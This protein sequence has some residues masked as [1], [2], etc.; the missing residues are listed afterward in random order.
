MSNSDRTDVR[1]DLD[2]L[3]ECPICTEVFTDPRSL[4]CIHT[5]CLRCIVQWSRNG[6][7]GDLISCPMC[8]KKFSIPL[9]GLECLPK[10]FFMERLKKT[11]ELL[12]SSTSTDRSLCEACATEGADLSGIEMRQRATN[13][14]IDCHQRFCDSCGDLH[15]KINVARMHRTIR[16]D[17]EESVEGDKRSSGA[18]A[19][20]RNQRLPEAMC[21]RHVTES[22]KLFCDNCE[23]AICIMCF[24]ECHQ[25]HKCSDVNQV[26]DVFRRRMTEDADELERGVAK[27]HSW[28][29]ELED[30]KSELAEVTTRIKGEID[31]RT[32]TL[33]R[34]VEDSRSKLM[35]ELASVGEKKSAQIG[36]LEEVITQRR[37][38]MD[39]L[40]RYTDELA[41]KGAASDIARQMNALRNS[42]E[43]LLNFDDIHRLLEA[44]T[45]VT[46]TFTSTGS[47]SLQ[48]GITIGKV[49]LQMS[50]ES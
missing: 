31:E 43:E 29:N 24:V 46:L 13:Y 4:P 37:L 44:M 16:F 2:D 35:K 6:R 17:S 23:D 42:T 20:L 5:Y 28:V 19:A 49:Q 22:L 48:K 34:L 25:T 21:D 9:G 3:T 33:K 30:R 40:K 45:T 36:D 41:N 38:L 15:R 27:C 14:C 26:V 1:K 7:P 12:S 18:I 11:N 50:V 32:E 8:L 10:N 39:S 47:S